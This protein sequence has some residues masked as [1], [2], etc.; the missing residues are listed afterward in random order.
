MTLEFTEY[1]EAIVTQT[2][3]LLGHLDGADLAVPVPS[4]PEW[5]VGQLARHLG[6]AHRWSERIV[7]SRATEP[8]PD[9]FRDLSAC[10]DEDPA[11][12]RPWLAEG[13]ALRADALRDSGPGGQAWS[14]VPGGAQTTDFYARRMTHETAVHRADAALALG[15]EYSLEPRVAVDTIDEWMALG[16]LPEMLDVKPHLRELLGPGRTLHLH[17]TDTPSELEAEW[18]VDLTGDSPAWRRAHEKCAV[19]VRGPLTDLVLVL[20]RRRPVGAADVEVLG[21]RAL[22]DHWLDNV[23][24]G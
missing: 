4:C 16:W 23:A 17:A 8:V 11:V 2:D 7:R 9:D 10:T 3:L 21:D 1:C 22:L 19:A 6:G 5:N 15:V 13:A 12:V 24:F 20:Y 14:P 18:V